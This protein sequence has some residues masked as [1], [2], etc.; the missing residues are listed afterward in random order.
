MEREKR[1]ERWSSEKL[2]RLTPFVKQL[3]V[4][5]NVNVELEEGDCKMRGCVETQ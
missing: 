3:G 5:T 2:Q 4:M 1:K